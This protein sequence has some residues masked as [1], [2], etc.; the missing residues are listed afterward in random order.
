MTKLTFTLISLLRLSISFISP[1]VGVGA[2]SVATCVNDC[3]TSAAS[4][5]GCASVEDID[6]I[7]ASSTFETIAGKCISDNACTTLSE[8]DDEDSAKASYAALSLFD[9]LSPAG[10]G[11]ADGVPIR[12]SALFGPAGSDSNLEKR[13]CNSGSGFCITGGQSRCNSY[14]T[15]CHVNSQ[16]NCGVDCSS[17]LCTGT[18]GLT[19][20]CQVPCFIC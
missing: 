6:C 20:A 7:K 1:Q 13:Q 8:S 9:A 16:G 2:A 12:R 3:F 5:V 18:L 11:H 10:D 19:C 15:S 4:E 14:C 17:G